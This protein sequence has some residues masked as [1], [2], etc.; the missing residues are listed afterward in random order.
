MR[1]VR[2]T[3]KQ[4]RRQGSKG[5]AP[6]LSLMF[7]EGAAVRDSAVRSLSPEDPA[8]KVLVALPDRM[9]REK[10]L[11]QAEVALRLLAAR[12]QARRGPDISA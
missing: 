6:T 9:P 8:L 5:S 2:A 10:Y 1:P 12:E 7:E 3:Q 11:L 4:D